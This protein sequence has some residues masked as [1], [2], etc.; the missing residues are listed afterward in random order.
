VAVEQKDPLVGTVIDGRYRILAR[1]A[2]GGMGVVY[3]AEQVFLKR[4]V[5]LKRLHRELTGHGQAM[6]RFAREAQAAVKINHPNVCQ[7]LDCGVGTDGVLF[8]AMEL[9]EGSSLGRR[10]AEA[11][12]LPLAEI[13]DIGAQICDGLQRAHSMGVIHRDLKPDNVMLVPRPDG[14]GV[15]A[16]I[17]DFGVAKVAHDADGK[18]LTQAGM[19]FGTPKYMAPEQASGEQL[20]ARADIYALGVILFEMATGKA[21]FDAPTLSGLLTKHLTEPPPTLEEA[22]PHLTYPLVFREVV[23][24]CL[25]KDPDHRVPNAEALAAILR[26]CASLSASHVGSA[27][28]RSDSAEAPTVLVGHAAPAK[29]DPMETVTT[30]FE[31]L[32]LA[33]GAPPAARRLFRG[34]GLAL[35]ALVFAGLVAG[36]VY[37]L[38]SGGEEQRRP[39]STADVPVAVAP[40][41][42]SEIGEDVAPPEM[43]LPPVE[44]DAVEPILDALADFADEPP[45]VPEAPTEAE[46]SS[47]EPDAPEEAEVVE[48]TEVVEAAE[49]RQASRDELAK[50]AGDERRAFEAREDRILRALSL[51]ARGRTHDAVEKLVRLASDFEGNAHYHFELAVL[52]VRDGH[53]ADGIQNAMR[54]I[55]LDPRYVG[56]TTLQAAAEQCLLQPASAEVATL[57]LEQVADAE[58][59]D[60]LV[61]WVM[62]NTRSV[63][64]P[65]RVRDLLQRR[66]LLDGVPAYLRLPLLVIVTEDC[67]GRRGWLGEIVRSP[68]ARMAQ[69]LRRFRSDT[70]CGRRRKHDCWPCERTAL[71]AAMAAVN[72]APPIIPG[73]TDVAPTP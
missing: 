37:L 52:Q 32:P 16:K 17:M 36:A 23:A 55:V 58:F 50:A 25:V 10:I 72:A 48:E 3:R 8:I 57:F 71:D 6:A 26:S 21:P 28:G 70:G 1:I 54:A 61:Q 73:V 34:R 40:P 68:D 15:T 65:T 12:P 69:F 59:A 13:V 2:A 4:E 42:A 35:F 18:A 5:A 9:L 14:S 64:T 24:R 19:V 11:A 20:D 46:D 56:D 53:F 43:P 41:D 29:P 49:V 67:E 47:E 51:A 62:E 44:P 60:S 38:W 63:A 30:G 7:V 31:Q 66:G 22:A 39:A 45:D 27:A 33:D